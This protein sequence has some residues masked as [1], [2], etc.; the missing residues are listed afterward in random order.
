MLEVN[1]NNNNR[2]WLDCLWIILWLLNKHKAQ[3]QDS[4]KSLLRKIHPINRVISTLP[5]KAKLQMYM[6]IMFNI[7]PNIPIEK[8]IMRMYISVGDRTYIKI[9]TILAPDIFMAWAMNIYLLAQKQTKYDFVV[10]LKH[11]FHLISL[12]FWLFERR[13]W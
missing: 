2:S 8:E 9:K 5:P 7:L 10:V 11:T 4:S 1:N 12:I 6:L 13:K 3:P